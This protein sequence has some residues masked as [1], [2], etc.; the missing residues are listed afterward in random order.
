M[1][2]VKS[3]AWSAGVGTA[4]GGDIDE[5]SS[6]GCSVTFVNVEGLVRSKVCSK[7][8]EGML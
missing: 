7:K 5:E 8:T 4:V 6:Q 2:D 1:E 3:V